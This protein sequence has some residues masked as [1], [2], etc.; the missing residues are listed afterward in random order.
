[1]G[2]LR[3]TDL[4]TVSSWGG[5]WDSLHLLR[6]ACLMRCGSDTYLWV[7]WLDW[8]D[9]HRSSIVGVTDS[10]LSSMTSLGLGSCI[11]SQNQTWFFSYRVSLS[12]I[13]H[14]WA[15]TNMWAALVASSADTV[16]CWSPLWFLGAAVGRTVQLLPFLGN[17]HGTMEVKKV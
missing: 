8:E 11:S 5:F 9:S 17:P 16:P 3:F 4:C 10:F 6:E 15:T 13:R 7:Q 14:M 12:P 2:P 1:M